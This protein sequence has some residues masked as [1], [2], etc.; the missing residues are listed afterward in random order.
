MLLSSIHKY[1]RFAE[2]TVFANVYIKPEDS[3]PG[4]NFLKINFG[5]PL[6]GLK[7]KHQTLCDSECNNLL[8]TT[9]RINSS[10]NCRH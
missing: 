10:C 9:A 6:Q 2:H 3:I 1:R 8:A 4:L 5:A 7:L